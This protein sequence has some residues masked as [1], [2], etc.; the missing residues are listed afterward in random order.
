KFIYQ[1]LLESGFSEDEVNFETIIN[2]LEELISYYANQV[3]SKNLPSYIRSF[4]TPIFENEL[5]NFEKEDCLGTYKIHLPKRNRDYSTIA[6]NGE[7]PN[8]L[9]FQELVQE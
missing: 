2:V 6:Q 5:L 9:F 8:Q 7:T 1:R 3:G 4:F